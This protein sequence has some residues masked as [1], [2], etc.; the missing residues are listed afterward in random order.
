ML[1]LDAINILVR[2]G[3]TPAPETVL[4]LTQELADARERIAALETALDARRLPNVGDVMLEFSDAVRAFAL[5][6]RSEDRTAALAAFDRAD[7]ALAADDPRR[8]S[9]RLLRETMN[10]VTQ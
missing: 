6:R 9:L 7:A 5:S 8:V 1:D 3:C 4:A 2:A 10:G